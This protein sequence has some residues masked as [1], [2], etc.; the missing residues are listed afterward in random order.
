VFENDIFDSW[1]NFDIT[2]KDEEVFFLKELLAQEID[3][4]RIDNYE[5]N[6]LLYTKKKAEVSNNY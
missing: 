6:H 3:F 5:R 1:F 4:I 2:L